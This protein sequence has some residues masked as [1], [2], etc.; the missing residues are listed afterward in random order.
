MF[1]FIK[2]PYD[3][4]DR[5]VINEAQLVV[6]HISLLY[7][8]FRRVDTNRTVQIPNIVSNA[9]WIENIS[10]SKAMKEQIRMSINAD[11]SFEDIEL[12]RLELQTFLAAPENKR[13]FLPDLEI[14]LLE[15]DM[16]EMKL[17]VE[18][19]HKVFVSLCQQKPVNH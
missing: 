1:I 7:T 12:L 6:E 5:V 13:D 3:V 15:T 17:R 16:K 9:T 19:S 18:V 8:V 14:E 11:T 10:R 2:H 4:G